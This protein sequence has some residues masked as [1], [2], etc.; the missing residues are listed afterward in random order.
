MIKKK[1]MFNEDFEESDISFK[2]TNNKNTNKKLQL[3]ILY[4][5]ELLKNNEENSDNCTFLQMNTNGTF[6]GCHNLELFK[7]VLNKIKNTNKEFILLSSGSSAEKIYT[8]CL[9]MKEIRECYIYCMNRNKYLPLI[10][11]YHKLKGVYNIFSEFKEKLFSLKKI[12]NE[13]IKSSNLIYFEDYNE[14]YIKLHYE[15]IRKYILYRKLKSKNFNEE[16]F[17]LYIKKE[18]PYFLELAKQLFPNKKEIIDFFKKNTN[19]N[20]S[21]ILKIFNSED[22]AIS[23]I[24][25][26]TKEGFYYRYLNKFLREGDFDAFRI[27]SS[28]ASKFIYFLYEYRKK[29]IKNHDNS[30]LYRKMYINRKEIQKYSSSIGRVI[31]F[32]SFTSTT[33]DKDSFTSSKYNYED[34]LVLLKISQ[35]N[36]KSVV[37]ISKDSEYESEKEY[38]FLPFSFFK[39]ISVTLNKG[40]TSDPH[41]IKLLAIKTKK[42]IE[43]MFVD[44]IENITDNLDPEGLDMLLYDNN[45]KEIY[46]NP[47]YYDN[48]KYNNNLHSYNIPLYQSQNLNQIGN[49]KYNEKHYFSKNN[50]MEN[51][52][53]DIMDYKYC[54]QINFAKK[55]NYDN[56]YKNKKCSLKMNNKYNLH[57]NKQYYDNYDDYDDHDDYDDFK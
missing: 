37:S 15:F 36:T 34:E 32:P 38:L 25:N 20:E 24:K 4:Y 18:Y 49:Y 31:C 50:I 57:K 3:N 23:Y 52:Y 45:K 5:D 12:K 19:E 8:F 40:N 17:L 11:K 33:L 44:F 42:P 47:I 9:E 14:I 7:L 2:G 1:E 13:I 55:M 35:N 43:D 6:Y 56:D 29:N 53:E 48:Y 10:H 46:F 30:D 21:N 54:T 39:I 51:E 27:L 26:Y 16:E 28:Y 41:I 22:N